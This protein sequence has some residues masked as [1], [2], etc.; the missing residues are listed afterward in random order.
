MLHA[1]LLPRVSVRR[2]HLLPLAVRSSFFARSGPS[3]R[4]PFRPPA[5]HAILCPP[6]TGDDRRLR[7]T[8]CG[9]RKSHTVPGRKDEE[10]GVVGEPF[11]RKIGWH[12]DQLVADANTNRFKFAP[13][14]MANHFCLGSIFA[15]SVFNEPLTSLHGVLTPAASDW[16]L[17]ETAPVFSLVMGGFVWGAIFGKYLDAWGPRACCLIGATGLGGGFGL[18]AMGSAFHSIPLLY[19]GGLVWGLC[20]GWA[21]VPPVATLLK[22]FPDRKGL[23]SGMCIMGYGGGAS[24]CTFGSYKLLR[25]FREAPEF[26]GAQSDVAIQNVDGKLFAETAGQLREVVVANSSSVA[27]WA[28]EGLVEG[29]Y[30]VGTGSTGLVETM[31]TLGS[32]YCLGMIACS[33]VYKLP[34]PGYSPTS[35]LPSTEK[36]N[37]KEVYITTHNVSPQVASRTPQFWLM[38][39][40]FGCAVTGSYGIISAGKTLMTDGFQSSLP[41]V[42]TAGFATSFVAA[43]SIANLS[44][45]LFWTTVSDKLATMKGG[46]PFHGRKMAYS[47]M[48]GICPPMYLAVVWSVHEC[49]DNPT[50]LPLAV[51]TGS[52]M[53]IMASFGGTAAARPAL[54]GD[55]FGL[56]HVGMLSARQLSVVLPAAM[57]GPRIVATMRESASYEAM[58]DL[59]SKIDDEAFFK[60]FASGKDQLQLLMEQN[61]VTISRL[62]ELVPPGTPDPTPFLYDNTMFVMAGI[63]TC[64][65]LTN[66]FMQPVDPS[67]HEGAK[68]FENQH[69]GDESS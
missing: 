29:V 61:T 43:M 22:W 55:L 24:L 39:L 60:A 49:A 27:S 46:D 64:A 35:N 13:A 36:G 23:A 12:P 48:W 44:G 11:L 67:K 6:V 66:Q 69:S 50:V 65:F 17:A 37:E 38:Y 56:K 52:V 21:Y 34:P 57:A 7:P 5:L 31:A 42:V 10:N 59:A 16:T 18:V 15:W 51:F 30:A 26:I 8:E 47:L 40:G 3:H 63:Q 1:A 14:A 58:Q 4:V 20:N 25:Y 68:V 28:D 53:G 32:V 19:T 9:Y 2:C 33:F 41:M 45:R 54:C 62:M